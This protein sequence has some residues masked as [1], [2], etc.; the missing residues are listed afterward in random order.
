M[1]PSKLFAI[2]VTI[3]CVGLILPRSAF[4]I[5]RVGN[6]AIGDAVQGYTAQV[7]L[8]FN[9]ISLGDKGSVSLN[10]NYLFNPEFGLTEFIQANPFSE[11]YPELVNANS[12]TVLAYFQSAPQ[13]SYTAVAVPNCSLSLLGEGPNTWVGISTWGNGAGYVLVTAK[14]DEA[15]QGIL[16][17]LQNTEITTPCWK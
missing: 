16:T 4:P 8:D 1:Q 10:S 3:A 7:P 12:A 5:G 15:K 2:S 9:Q 6:G 13:M 14:T 11:N 17:M